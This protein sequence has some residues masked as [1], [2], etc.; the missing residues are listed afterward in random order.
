MK[1]FHFKP[2]RMAT[3]IFVTTILTSNL[4]FSECVKPQTNKYY[5]GVACLGEGLARVKLNGKWGYINKIGKEVIPLKYDY[6]YAFREGLAEAELNKKW[7]FIDRTG[8]EIIPIKYDY[9]GFFKE[10]LA[11]VKLNGKWGFIDKTGKEVIPIKYDE[12]G[13][14]TNSG[15]IILTIN[16]KL[17]E[18]N[19]QGNQIKYNEIK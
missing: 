16:G 3:A 4:A 2:S 6:L 14:S 19:K 12:V 1:T 5:D 18:V 13:R 17:I 11:K 10:G 15:K 9:L 8:K 7:G